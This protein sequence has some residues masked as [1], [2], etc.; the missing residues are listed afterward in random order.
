MKRCPKC[1]SQVEETSKFC[2]SC[3]NQLFDES[4]EKTEVKSEGRFCRNCGKQVSVGFLN[5]PFCGANMVSGIVSG[6]VSSSRGY[7]DNY[8]L[9]SKN[10]TATFVLGLIGT[11]LVALN[12]LGVFF[13]HT[14]GFILG[15]IGLSLAS[16]DKKEELTYSKAGYV[17]S[18]IAVIAGGIAFLIGMI[19]GLIT[20]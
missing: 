14:I 11:I 8:Y 15:V 13:V 20:S 7:S 6:N 18:L 17:L 3:G 1:L 5:C 19:F 2:S 9:K 16:K 12:Y 4:Q 10:H